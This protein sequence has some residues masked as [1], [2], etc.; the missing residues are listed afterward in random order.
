M[1]FCSKKLDVYG[2]DLKTRRAYILGAILVNL[3]DM[4]KLEQEF[5]NKKNIII[6]KPNYIK[7]DR[8]TYAKSY[9]NFKY[10]QNFKL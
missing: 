7:V 9:R 1:F 4:L 2:L 8:R 10:N 3:C 6:T 5:Y